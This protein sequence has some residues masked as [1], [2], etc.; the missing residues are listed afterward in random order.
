ME[1]AVGIKIDYEKNRNNPEQIFSAMALYISAY[2]KYGNLIA[3]EVG[4]ELNYNLCLQDIEKSSIKALLGSISNSF[5]SLIT[6]QSNGLFED[7]IDEEDILSPDQ[8]DDLARKQES[9]M[10]KATGDI[11]FYIDR[12]EFAKILQEISAANEML[13]R[14]EKAEIETFGNSNNN[15]IRLNTRMRFFGDPETMFDEHKLISY[16]GRDSLDIIKP[17]NFGDSQ[18]QVRSRTTHKTFMATIGD[19]QWLKLYQNGEIPIITA[20]YCMLVDMYCELDKKNKKTI[21]K[22]AIIIK[23][24]KVIPSSEAQDALL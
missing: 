2:K 22:K 15:I 18:W 11:S 20:K 14:D 8:V 10:E 12:V 5:N 7:L 19:K 13:Y 16:R 24:L 6:K 23:V 3:K 1:S 21:I 4:S 17:V 9:K